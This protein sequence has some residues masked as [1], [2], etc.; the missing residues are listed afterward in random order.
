MVREMGVDEEV[1]RGGE[2]GVIEDEMMRC[3]GDEKGG[4]GEEEE[5]I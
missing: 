1:Y 4:M 5:R 3:Y 2:R